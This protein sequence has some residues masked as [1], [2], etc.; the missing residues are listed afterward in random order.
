MDEPNR[1]DYDYSDN[2]DDA[3]AD[4]QADVSN[5]L[6]NAKTLVEAKNCADD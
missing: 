5:C 1:P 3:L 4:Y 6:D 2:C